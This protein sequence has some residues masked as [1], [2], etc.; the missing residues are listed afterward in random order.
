[1][2][3]RVRSNCLRLLAFCALC[4]A[5]IGGVVPTSQAD[6]SNHA[7]IIVNYGDHVET[8]C[9]SFA[10]SEI[11]G[12]E[13]LRRAGL[14]VIGK[15]YAGIGEAVCKIN[16]TGCT[17]PGEQCWCQCLGSPCIF[18]SYWYWENGAWKYSGMGAS[19]RKV[20]DGGVDAWVWGDGTTEPPALTFDTL[21]AQATPTN[22]QTPLPATATPTGTPTRT[23]TVT[24]TPL[25]TGTPTHTPTVTQTPLYTATPTRTGTQTATPTLT[26]AVPTATATTDSAYP[27]GTNTPEELG[28]TVTPGDEY[29]SDATETPSP[30]PTKTRTPTATLSATPGPSP[31]STRTATPGPSPTPTRTGRRTSTPA[32]GET[33]QPSGTAQPTDILPNSLQQVAVPYTP[34]AE[35]PTQEYAETTPASEAMPAI[36]EEGATAPG[37]RD[38]LAEDAIAPAEPFDE[39]DAVAV[40][41]L[42]STSV[43]NERA[44][45]TPTT[46]ERV[47]RRNYGAFAAVSVILLGLVGYATL[48]QK[49]RRREADK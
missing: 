38:V 25:Y 41:A 8:Y 29:P 46:R 19:S 35:T 18:W 11:S 6:G 27:N 22:T 31:T 24:Q 42:I 17:F 48:L 49:Q 20:H 1:M 14:S 9:V 5:V 15:A 28:A 21:C 43:A 45:P 16:D 36:Q 34:G 7:G 26:P 30:T 47:A 37:Q 32:T 4:V 10:E 13:L 12:V 33:I 44:T 39:A 3:T 40:A 2:G 23:S